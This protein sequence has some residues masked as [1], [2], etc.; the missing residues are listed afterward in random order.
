M[1]PLDII[2]KVKIVLHKTHYFAF[3]TNMA[4]TWTKT[5]EYKKYKLI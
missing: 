1:L 2:W 5:E 3:L 4:K